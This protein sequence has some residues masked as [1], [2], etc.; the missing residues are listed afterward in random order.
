MTAARTMHNLIDGELVPASDGRTDAVVNPATGQEIGQV[1]ASGPDDVRQAVANLY[2]T[3]WRSMGMING[4]C[5][6]A[7]EPGC[8]VRVPGVA[9]TVF[10]SSFNLSGCGHD[11]SGRLVCRFTIAFHCGLKE[12]GNISSERRSNPF[13]QSAYCAE[14]AFGI[15]TDGQAYLVST[16]DGWRILPERVSN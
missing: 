2:E 15:P 5:S 10:I 14:F 12:L 3:T 1:P 7:T 13:V 8:T 6:I 4:G 9:Q 16:P 11:K